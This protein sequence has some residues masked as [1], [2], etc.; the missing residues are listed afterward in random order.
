MPPDLTV[1]DQPALDFGTV[2]IRPLRL[3]D[4]TGCDAVEAA[5]FA[6]PGHRA[7]PDKFAYRLT[8]CPE[9]CWG[10]FVRTSESS[11]GSDG[12][13]NGDNE[14]DDVLV[15]HTVATRCTTPVVTDDSMH[16]PAGWESSV[17]PPPSPDGHQPN[18]HTVALHSLAIVP[19]AQGRGLGTRLMRAYVA[20]LGQE[21][22]PK[23]ARV[24]L[25]C[26]DV[27]LSSPSSVR[28]PPD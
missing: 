5:A 25:I 9:L 17:P 27:S 20:A 19:A 22:A 12:I 11:A 7:T 28:F 4:R 23:V 1:A 13:D 10:V 21:T 26:Q 16:V 8:V 6:N 15:G 24:A 2:T 3:A 14:L 18:G